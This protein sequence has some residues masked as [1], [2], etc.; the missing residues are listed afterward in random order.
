MKK[1]LKC[2]QEF[3]HVLFLKELIDMEENALFIIIADDELL[4]PWR[5]GKL[6][7]DVRRALAEVDSR[8]IFVQ[9]SLFYLY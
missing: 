7:E 2:D 6:I 4:V 1:S 9:N 5:R 3:F 8:E